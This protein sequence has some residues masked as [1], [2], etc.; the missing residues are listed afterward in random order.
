M[1]QIHLYPPF[2]SP[3]LSLSDGGGH[4]KAGPVSNKMTSADR[5]WLA[6]TGIGTSIVL[7]SLWLPWMFVPAEVALERAGMQDLISPGSK[8][9]FGPLATMESG[10]F[11]A[12]DLGML[13]PAWMFILLI[14]ISGIM[15]IL[16][17]SRVFVVSVWLSVAPLLVAV[18]ILTYW[19][20]RSLGFG[21]SLGAGFPF[22]ACGSAMI[23]FAAVKHRRMLNKASA[24]S[25][26]GSL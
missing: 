3:E 25:L 6:V 16:T 22:A 12:I 1:V 9:I 10:W 7:L 5:N 21:C 26:T 11:G 24:P 18:I 17:I 8:E 20:V 13:V 19:A 23:A 2:V 4:R 15:A 14:V